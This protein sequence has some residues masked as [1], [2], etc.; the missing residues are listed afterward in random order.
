MTAVSEVPVPPP[1]TACLATD[2][3]RTTSAITHV[4]IAK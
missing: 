1:S 4:P 3:P 2:E